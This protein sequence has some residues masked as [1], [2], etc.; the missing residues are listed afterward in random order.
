[1]Y[2]FCGW[3][4]QK[5]M[6][7]WS[8]HNNSQQWFLLHLRQP[9]MK[10]KMKNVRWSVATV[11][12]DGLKFIYWENLLCVVPFRQ[13]I[14]WLVMLA[15]FPHLHAEALNMQI[16]LL[17]IFLLG[18]FEFFFTKFIFFSGFVLFFLSRKHSLPH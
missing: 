7:I 12:A 4:W 14:K 10:M 5:I 13:L 17:F 2:S 3:N 16:V 6:I 9:M 15:M 1:M 18:L 11:C 8:M